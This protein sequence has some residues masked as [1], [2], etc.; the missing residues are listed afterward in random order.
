[1]NILAGALSE[2][3]CFPTPYDTLGFSFGRGQNKKKLNKKKREEKKAS[4]LSCPLQAT[5]EPLPLCKLQ[6][7]GDFFPINCIIA[8]PAKVI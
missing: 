7:S 1:M 4:E 6:S 3:W 2:L 5:A 8:F